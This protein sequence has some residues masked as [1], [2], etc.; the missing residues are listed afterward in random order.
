MKY[1]LYCCLVIAVVFLTGCTS[2]QAPSPP[3]A[4]TK[5]VILNNTIKIIMGQTVYVPIY[6]H[7]YMRDQNQMMDLTATLSVR[8]TDLAYPLIVASVNYYDTN[9]KPIRKY[10]KQ[11]IE[12]GPLSAT[13]FVVNQVDTSGGSGAAFVVEWMAQQQITAPV[14]ESVMI[15]TSGNQGLS[16]V[17]TGRVVKS[18]NDSK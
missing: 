16:F 4:K 1:F 2:S 8:N 11:P 17:S 7:I 15:N 13:S 5:T 6:S 14:I 18:R 3:V 10:L 9:G 12:L